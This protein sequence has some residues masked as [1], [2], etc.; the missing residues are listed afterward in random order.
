[1]VIKTVV[2]TNFIM[3]MKYLNNNNNSNVIFIGDLIK[4]KKIPQ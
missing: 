4:Q 2:E 1:M 3:L